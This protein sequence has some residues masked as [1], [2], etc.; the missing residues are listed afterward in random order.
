M[1]AARAL[2]QSDAPE[3]LRLTG[4]GRARKTCGHGRF[5]TG[6]SGQLM[7]ASECRPVMNMLTKI[8]LNSRQPNASRWM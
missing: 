2:A 8:T 4:N 7:P 5:M 3:I 1:A 6:N